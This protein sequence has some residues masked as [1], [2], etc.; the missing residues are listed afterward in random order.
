MRCGGCM[1][2][3][4]PHPH[5]VDT[6]GIVGLG[7]VGL[8]LAAAFAGAGISVMGVEAN[9]DKVAALFSGE[10]Y[11]DGVPAERLQPLIASGKL[12]PTEGYDVLKEVQAAII[13]LP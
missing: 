3:A 1:R 10:S 4:K 2:D 7:F 12:R 8:P 6:I 5:L 13:C 9:R 11:I